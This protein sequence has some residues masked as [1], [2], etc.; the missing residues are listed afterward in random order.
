MDSVQYFQTHAVV[1]LFY[2][3]T[4]KHT[5]HTA[6]SKSSVKYLYISSD[7]LTRGFDQS[8]VASR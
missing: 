6:A 7:Q 4:D 1:F 8:E 5:K 2:A 3:H